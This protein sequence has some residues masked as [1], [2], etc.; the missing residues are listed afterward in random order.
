MS[1]LEYLLSLINLQSAT[2][3]PSIGHTTGSRW[4]R[5]DALAELTYALRGESRVP[6]I[7]ALLRHAPELA[8]QQ[9]R[10]EVRMKLCDHL[11]VYA[12][13]LRRPVSADRLADMLHRIAVVAMVELVEWQPCAHCHGKGRVSQQQEG[14]GIVEVIC[15][16]CHGARRLPWSDRKRSRA[17]NLSLSTAQNRWLELLEFAVSRLEGWAAEGVTAIRSAGV[18]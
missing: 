9:E 17:L 8:G 7:C 12:H 3:P 18:D 13:T 10:S 11:L 15:P 16:R 1:R 5:E 2:R 6:V 14:E 4:T